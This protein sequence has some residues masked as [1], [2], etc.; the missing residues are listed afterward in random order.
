MSKTTRRG[1]TPHAEDWLKRQ[2]VQVTGM[3]PEDPEEA[4]AV[5][6]YSREIVDYLDKGSGR[7][8]RLVGVTGQD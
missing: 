6:S 2:A 3:L 7:R 4:R 1:R 5:L 8:L